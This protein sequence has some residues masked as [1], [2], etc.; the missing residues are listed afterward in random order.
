MQSAHMVGAM[1]P[2]DSRHYTDCNVFY[3][4]ECLFRELFI[5]TMSIAL[6]ATG[7]SFNLLWLQAIQILLLN[8]QPWGSLI[9]VI[10]CAA[11]KSPTVVLATSS[12]GLWVLGCRLFVLI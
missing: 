7:S 2:T 6:L 10:C 11:C 9:S 4:F 1:V 5:E 12:P 8:L 3:L